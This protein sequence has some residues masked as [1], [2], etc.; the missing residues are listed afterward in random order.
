MKPLLDNMLTGMFS[1][2]EEKMCDT[3]AKW[4][5]TS[6]DCDAVLAGIAFYHMSGLVR[7]S[8]FWLSCVS[9]VIFSKMATTAEL[10]LI[11]WPWHS[12]PFI[13]KT[14]AA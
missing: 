3:C 6:L 7:W 11:A 2:F 14:L 13:C 10:T 5:R 8:K 9:V 12:R 1:V 4:P